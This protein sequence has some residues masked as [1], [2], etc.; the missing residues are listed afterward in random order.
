[1]RKQKLHAALNRE[2]SAD[3]MPPEMQMRPERYELI[4]L[5]AYETLDASIVQTVLPPQPR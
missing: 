3:T 1:M 5:R 4:D 2:G